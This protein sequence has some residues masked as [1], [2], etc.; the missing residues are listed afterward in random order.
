MTFLEKM[1]VLAIILITVSASLVYTYKSEKDA[2]RYL[3][4]ELGLITEQHHACVEGVLYNHHGWEVVMVTLD[5]KP[6]H[7]LEEVVT[8]SNNMIKQY[9]AFF[10]KEIEEWMSL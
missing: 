2:H 8:I 10:N 5:S 6:I 7:C 3:V 4:T 9:E 1:I